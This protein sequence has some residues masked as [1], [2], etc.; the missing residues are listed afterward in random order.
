[1]HIPPDKS[2]G[3]ETYWNLIILIYRVHINYQISEYFAKPYFY[4]YLTEIHV[5]TTI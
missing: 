4:K 5:V 3:I 1:M 2:A